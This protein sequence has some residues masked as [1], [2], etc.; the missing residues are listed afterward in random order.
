VTKECHKKEGARR[1]ESR[2]GA[3]RT[4]RTSADE[5]GKSPRAAF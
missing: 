4:Q 1:G 2:R 3:I 5:L